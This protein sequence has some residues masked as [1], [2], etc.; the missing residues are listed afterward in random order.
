MDDARVLTECERLARRLGLEVRRTAGGPSGLCTVRGERALFLDRGLGD[1][2]GID[3]YVRAFRTMDLGGVFVVP[4]IR[5]LLEGDNA[6]TE[7]W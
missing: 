1:R 6:D 7:D 4:V 5:R 2:S 3:V